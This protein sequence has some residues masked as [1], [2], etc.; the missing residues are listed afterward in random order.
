M[1]GSIE[2]P[3]TVKYEQLKSS[4]F[5]EPLEFGDDQLITIVSSDVFTQ[6]HPPQTIRY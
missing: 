6:G 4:Y 1:K 5:G 2:P 3:K